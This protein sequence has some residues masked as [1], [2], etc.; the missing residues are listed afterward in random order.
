ATAGYNACD[1]AA[2]PFKTTAELT[3]LD[4]P[5]GQ[6]R[7]MAA[8]E[9][10]AAM[11]RQGYNLYVM[12]QPGTGRSSIV[13]Q[14]LKQRALNEPRPP[15]WCYVHTFADPSKPTALDLPPGRATA[16]RKAMADLVQEL[17]AAL[18]AAFDTDE[19]RG[20]RQVIDEELKRR[21]DA[22]FEA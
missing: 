12:G 17:K 21:H 1:P 14:W 8:L 18:P 7:A 11:R 19:Y 6:E 5:L 10:G 20:R 16:L 15:A 22:A 2:L 9:F 3:P 4:Q 13:S